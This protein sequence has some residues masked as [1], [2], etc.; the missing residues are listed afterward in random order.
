MKTKHTE[1]MATVAHDLQT[2][3]SALKANICLMTRDKSCDK[4]IRACH[5]LIDCM[6]AMIHD[7]LAFAR[8]HNPRQLASRRVFSISTSVDTVLEYVEAIAQAYKITL[9]SRIQP[10]IMVRGSQERIEEALLNIISNSMKYLEKSGIRVITLSLKRIGNECIIVVKDTGIGIPKEE[11]PHVFTRF[12]RTTL[13]TRHATGSGLGLA[14]TKNIV[15]AHKGLIAIASTEGKGTQVEIRL[16][17]VVKGSDPKHGVRP[18]K[19]PKK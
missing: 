8:S 4:E 2:P 18:Q 19:R 13:A 1:L 6:S 3:L 16:P 17:V 12:Y 5:D 15:E 10:G 9:I 11:L 14:I 7:I